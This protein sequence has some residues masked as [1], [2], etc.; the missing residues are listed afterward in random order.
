MSKKNMLQKQRHQMSSMPPWST[1]KIPFFERC[2]PF[3]EV[4]SFCFGVFGEVSDEV[5]DYVKRCAKLTAA[6]GG[7][8]SC[9]QWMMC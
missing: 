4:E 3:M 8:F 2:L 1:H 7:D 5:N 6:M 9:L